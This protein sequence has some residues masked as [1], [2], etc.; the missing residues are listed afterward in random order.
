E[1]DMYEGKGIGDKETLMQGGKDADAL[2]S[3]LSTNVDQDVIDAGSNLKIIANYGAGFKNVGIEDAKQKHIDVTN[4]PKA[5]TNSTAELTFALVLDV[6]RRI[7]EGDKLC[8]TTGFD[9]W[10]PLFFRGREVSGKTIGIIGLG[11]IG[12]AVAK[13]AKAFDMN[14]LYIGPNQKVDK[15]R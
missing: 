1:V 8:R 3:V 5:S 11:E 4:T 10:A 7:P 2:I 12:S 6:A 13:R 14:V 9:G 15:E